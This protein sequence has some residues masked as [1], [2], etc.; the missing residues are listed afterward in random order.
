MIHTIQMQCCKCI[1]DVQDDKERDEEKEKKTILYSSWWNEPTILHFTNTRIIHTNI[2]A[3]RERERG[4]GYQ[5]LY[6]KSECNRLYVLISPSIVFSF[7][8]V[9][10]V[11]YSLIPFVEYV[12]IFVSFATAQSNPYTLP[13]PHSHTMHKNFFG[14]IVLLKVYLFAICFVRF[15]V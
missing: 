7:Y 15:V 14:K 12:Y 3:E 2:Y 6:S 1:D 8:S 9:F 5:R 13:F 11:H 4:G 10:T